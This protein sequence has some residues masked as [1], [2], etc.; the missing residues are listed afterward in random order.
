ML[1]STRILPK[2]QQW[3]TKWSILWCTIT[4][5]ASETYFPLNCMAKSTFVLNWKDTSPTAS[6][7]WKILH[8]LI[9][10]KNWASFQEIG[11]TF[12]YS[13]KLNHD[14]CNVLVCVHTLILILSSS[15]ADRA[16]L[17][18]SDRKRILSKASD[19]L[20]INSL[21]KIYN[22]KLMKSQSWFLIA[23]F[24]SRRKFCFQA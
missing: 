17:S 24:L 14:Q 5:K 3:S 21:K 22:W 13:W 19:A 8:W 16:D 4:L 18:V 2:L 20:E 7:P 10:L 23:Y 9:S 12:L 1:S 6:I 11:Y 15:V